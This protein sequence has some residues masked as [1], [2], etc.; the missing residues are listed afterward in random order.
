M[1]EKLFTSFPF[2]CVFCICPSWKQMFLLVLKKLTETTC[3]FQQLGI[4]VNESINFESVISM[5]NYD[6]NLC[7]TNRRLP[8]GGV[9][10]KER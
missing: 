7:N 3:S 1:L 6:V 8:N 9:A 10:V 2:K 4:R 5:N